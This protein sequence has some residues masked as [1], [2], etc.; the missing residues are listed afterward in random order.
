[1]SDWA[2]K[3]K[4]RRQQLKKI[5]RG[6]RSYKS[7]YLL[8]LLVVLSLPLIALGA[9]FYQNYEVK[10]ELEVAGN[11]ITV[12]KGG[13]F[14]AALNRAK[15]GDTILL[16]AGATF[17]G[18]FVLPK[19]EGNEFITIRSS[20]SDSQLPP[21]DT[22]IEPNKYAAVLPKIVTTNSDPA[23][24]TAK[25]AHH[26]RFI[27]VE[28]TPDTDKYVY[29]LVMLGVENQQMN[30][31]PH[32]IEFDRCYLH[33]SPKGKTRRG[34]ALNNAETI[35]KNSHISGFAYRE[36]ET[37]AI[38]GWSGPGPFKI[39]NNYL[40]AGAENIMFGGAN[41]GIKG[42]VPSDI[43]IRG[44]Y[45][46]KP[47]EW[48]DTVGTKCVFELKNARRVLVSG[49]VMENSFYENAIRL[50]VRGENSTAPWSTIEDVVIENNLIRNSGGGVNILGVDDSGK[51][52]TMKRVKIINNLFLE[53]DAAKW[54]GDGRFLTIADGED[55][56]IANNTFFQSGNMITAHGNPSKKFTFR[57]NILAHNDYGTAGD[58]GVGK[59]VLARYFPNGVFSGNVIVNTKNV[60]KEYMVIPPQSHF[61]PNFQSLGFTNWQ[62]KDFRLLP[63]SA[64]R[65]KG[66][67]GKDPGVD[68][69]IF[70]KQLTQFLR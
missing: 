60:P 7:L 31:I 66:V 20:A 39:I 43:E 2:K 54:G 53:I 63:N 38:C 50:T 14:Q 34:I 30:E 51:S 45:M 26:Y 3:Q 11:T 25:G 69:S 6:G 55:I 33:P 49:N 10:T 18:N 8:V 56:T 9:Y 28:I 32:H 52:E 16:E 1:M 67:N 17:K 23:I 59:Q 42:L 27:G 40:E 47:L 44:N 68:F 35:I 62:G 65:G 5:E 46:S 19:K 15:S 70:E 41:P 58:N 22:R 24:S 61:A 29:N 48:R 37:Q 4:E 21:P 36:E 13:D 57:D 12:R 64:F